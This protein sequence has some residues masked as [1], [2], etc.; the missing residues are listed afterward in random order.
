V[1]E[2]VREIVLNNVSMKGHEG[3]PIQAKNYDE[4][5]VKEFDA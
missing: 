4:L 3:E 5:T 1:F 2:N